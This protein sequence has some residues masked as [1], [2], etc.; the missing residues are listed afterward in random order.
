MNTFCKPLI[1]N[2]IDKVVDMLDSQR[3]T[4]EK[5]TLDKAQ[6]LIHT[7]NML[8]RTAGLKETSRSTAPKCLYAPKHRWHKREANGIET[9]RCAVC[10]CYREKLVTEAGSKFYCYVSPHG[11]RSEVWL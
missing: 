2:N 9:A 11:Q 7:A 8:N 5:E 4:T 3:L 10:G 1:V 6:V